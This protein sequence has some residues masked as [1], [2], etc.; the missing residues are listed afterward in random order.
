MQ[1]II[2]CNEPVFMGVQGKN[3]A[4]DQTIGTGFNNTDGAIAI[5]YRK[6][7]ISCLR[8]AAHI[9]V[10]RDRHLALKDKTLGPPADSTPDGPDQIFSR[11]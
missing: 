10:F 9:A 3:G 11:I 8:R 6:G 4:P 1:G 7:E 5:F 2:C